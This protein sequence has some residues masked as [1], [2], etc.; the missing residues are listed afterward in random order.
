MKKLKKFIILTILFV[1]AAMFSINWMLNTEIG[2]GFEFIKETKVNTKNNVTNYLKT[3]KDEFVDNI[4]DT[5]NMEREIVTSPKDDNNEEE[6][7]QNEDVKKEPLNSVSSKEPVTKQDFPLMKLDYF[8]DHSSAPKNISKEQ[9]LEM[10]NKAS[11][12]WKQTC[13]IKFVYKGDR[14]ADYVDSDTTLNTKEGIVKWGELEEDAIG[15][16]HQGNENGPAFGFV[17]I[18]NNEYFEASSKVAK[19]EREQELAGTILHEMGHVIGLDHSKN[20][21]SVMYYQNAVYRKLNA[22]DQKM[23]MYYRSLWSGMSDSEASSKYEILMNK[24]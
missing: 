15:Q 24:K 19:K 8:Y 16:S 23:C 20:K 14:L 3:K 4:L 10:M 9:M 13:N 18:F 1:V 12:I 5:L 2:N 7:T 11:D 6:N 21:G 22:T 17:M